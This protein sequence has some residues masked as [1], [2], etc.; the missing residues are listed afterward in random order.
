[1]ERERLLR[2]AQYLVLIITAGF[3]GLTGEMSWGK[4]NQASLDMA[5]ALWFAAFLS[6]FIAQSLILFRTHYPSPTE[7]DESCFI[8]SRPLTSLFLS[9]SVCCIMLGLYVTGGDH[10]DHGPRNN[11]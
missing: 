5:P 1:M 8:S 2:A 7:S 11:K 4:N 6:L 3:T 10:T 9:A